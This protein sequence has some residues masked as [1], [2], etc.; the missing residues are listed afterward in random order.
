MDWT[1]TV[2]EV[3]FQKI[4]KY[5]SIAAHMAEILMESGSQKLISLFSCDLG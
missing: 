5:V 3:G 2:W 1:L 4:I